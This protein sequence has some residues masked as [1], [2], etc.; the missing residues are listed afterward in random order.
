L[1][2]GVIDRVVS[3]EGNVAD[4]ASAPREVA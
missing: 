2:Q 1:R 4:V 3:I